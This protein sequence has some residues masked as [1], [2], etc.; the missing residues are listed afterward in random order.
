MVTGVV[1]MSATTTEG[2]ELSEPLSVQQVAMEQSSGLG[3]SASGVWSEA[4][5]V[6][7]LSLQCES[8]VLEIFAGCA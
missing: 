7:Q 8:I 2:L 4:V 5:W 3:L 6:Q 1:F